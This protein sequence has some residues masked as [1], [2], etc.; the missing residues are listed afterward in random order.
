M[1]AVLGW[2][3]SPL[4]RLGGAGRAVLGVALFVGTLGTSL[5]LGWVLVSFAGTHDPPP[6]ADQ[7]A[8]AWLP[9]VAIGCVVAGSVLLLA[10]SIAGHLTGDRE[11]RPYREHAVLWITGVPGV[12][13]LV[14]AAVVSVDSAYR[15]R[16]V[17]FGASCGV[18]LWWLWL[19]RDDD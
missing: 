6:Y 9:S 5:M 3:L 7:P 2:L 14:V 18:A 19:S 11:R 10:A 4:S 12:F 13:G 8:P 1:A 17:L 15:W 16:P